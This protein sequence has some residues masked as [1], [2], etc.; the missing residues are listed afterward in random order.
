[1][2]YYTKH[3]YYKEHKCVS[4]GE[5]F[6]AKMYNS[7]Y[8]FKCIVSKQTPYK[9]LKTGTVGAIGEIMVSADLMKKG[10]EVFRALS[11]SCSC[12]IAIL[13]NK[14][15]LRVEVKTGYKNPDEKITPFN[16]LKTKEKKFD[17]LAIV[18]HRTNEI[19]YVPK[20]LTK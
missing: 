12:D 14:K 3:P 8:C 11:P 20:L 6:M 16:S 4:C 13:Q 2:N 5:S 1:M 19:V 17:I 18:I 9:N 7:K 15:L 10:Y